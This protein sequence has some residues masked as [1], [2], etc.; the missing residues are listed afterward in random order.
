M[1]I[2][3]NFTFETTSPMSEV[4][5]EFNPIDGRAR[6]VPEDIIATEDV[7]WGQVKGLFR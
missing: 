3:D 7:S 2:S 5:F 6:V 1:F 4:R